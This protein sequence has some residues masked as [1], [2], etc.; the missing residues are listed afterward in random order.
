M[1]GFRTVSV[2]TPGASVEFRERAVFVANDGVPIPEIV[3][4]DPEEGSPGQTLLVTVL[5]LDT[6]FENGFTEVVFGEGI[7]VS[8]ADVIDAETAVVE[9]T[10]DAAAE[11]G[12]RSVQATTGAETAVILDGFFVLPDGGPGDNPLEIPTLSQWGLGILILVLG[13][14]ATRRLGVGRSE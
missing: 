5:G 13:L 7:T 11:P 3:A 10:I 4:L 9:I 12:F 2:T 1:I 8:E 14:L 6:S